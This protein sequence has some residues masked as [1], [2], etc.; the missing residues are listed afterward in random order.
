MRRSRCR[1]VTWLCCSGPSDGATAGHTPSCRYEQHPRTP[2]VSAG[3]TSVHTA[4]SHRMLAG[5]AHCSPV[6]TGLLPEHFIHMVCAKL[7]ITAAY[8]YSAGCQCVLFLNPPVLVGLPY[9][10]CL[11]ET[12]ATGKPVLTPLAGVQTAL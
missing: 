4:E 1:M 10:Q 8:C 2:V 5:L 6:C 9:A 7:V 3:V 11:H 12:T